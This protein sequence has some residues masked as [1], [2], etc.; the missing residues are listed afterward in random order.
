MVLVPLCHTV[1]RCTV[2]LGQ[3]FICPRASQYVVAL[4]MDFFHDLLVL[5]VLAALFGSQFIAWV[6]L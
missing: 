4:N 2:R 1:R 5:R 3:D 6:S